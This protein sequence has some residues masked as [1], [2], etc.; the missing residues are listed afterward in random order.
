MNTKNKGNIA[1]TKACEFLEKKGFNILER[2]FY[3][4]GGEIDTIAYKNNTLHFIEVKSGFKFEPIYNITPA[5]I[6]RI[7]KGAHIYMRQKGFAS[8]PF[9]IDAIIIKGDSV[10]NSVEFFENLTLI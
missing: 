9:C 3:F 10:K 6:K 7:I 2:N 1:E 8:S 4:K 5:K